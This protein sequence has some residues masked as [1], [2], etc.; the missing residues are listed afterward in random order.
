[1]SSLSRVGFFSVLKAQR[2][3]FFRDKGG[4]FLSFVFPIFFAVTLIVNNSLTG[5]FT[6]NFG[7][8]DSHQNE[9]SQLFV[10]VLTENLM[11]NVRSKQLDPALKELNEGDLDA[12]LVI[13]KGDFISGADE[14]ELI[15]NPRFKEFI[16][17]IMDAVRAQLLDHGSERDQNNLQYQ[18]TVPEDESRSEFTFTYPGILALALLQLA[19]FGTAVPLL[20]A[21]ERGTIKYL[22]LTPLTA[23]QLLSSQLIIRFIVALLQIALLLAVGMYLLDLTLIDWISVLGVACMGIVMLT[24]IGY[25]IAGVAPNL[26]SGMAIVLI[27][28]FTMAFMGN[29]FWAPSAENF[30]LYFSYLIPLTYLSD[31][32]RQVVTGMPGLLPIW[33]D[34]AVII[35]ISLVAIIFTVRT[36]KFD[37]QQGKS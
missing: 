2:I 34:A 7:V 8:V 12:I 4:L 11:I 3:E 23:F 10:D 27:T 26:Q 22:L 25:A 35:G 36:F 14:V 28:N 30:S 19:L 1:M 15:V 18:V 31:M 5:N 33:A 32:F 13:P 16:S 20:Q 21:K 17:L 24:S 29:V 9:N 37:N 6:L